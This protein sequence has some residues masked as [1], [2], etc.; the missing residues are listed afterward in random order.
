MLAAGRGPGTETLHGFLDNTIIFKIIDGAIVNALPAESALRFNFRRSIRSGRASDFTVAARTAPLAIILLLQGP[1]SLFA[2]GGAFY[3]S[4]IERTGNLVPME[5]PLISLEKETFDAY[6]ARDDV[7][8]Y[9]TYLL[10]NHGPADSVTF[11]FPVDLATPETLNIPNGYDYV[12]ENSLSEFRVE[13]GGRLVPIEKTITKPVSAAERPAGLDPKIQLV[14]R[15]SLMT[16]KF[17]AGIGKYLTVS[18]KVRCMALDEGFEGDTL[19]KYGIRTFLYTFHPAATWGNGRV[20]S[21]NVA[22]DTKWLRENDLPPVARLA[23]P[24]S[25]DEAGKLRWTFHDQDLAKLHDLTFSYDPSDLYADA[26]IKR[27]LLGPAHVKSLIVSS[28]LPAAGSFNYGKG[29]MR[30]NDLRTA[31]AEGAKGPGIGETIIFEPKDAYVTEIALLNGFV[32]NEALYYANA[33]IKKLRVEVECGE[34]AEESERHQTQEIILPDRPYKDLNPR[35]PFAFVDWVVQHPSGDGFIQ[36]VKLTI[37]DV[38]PGRKYQDTAVTE[39]YI[40]G[41]GR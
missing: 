12:R 25:S 18:Y 14:R 2:N 21:L 26:Q 4:V 35:F 9:V 20:G 15:W 6:I 40:C 33:R 19:W 10:A 24:G 7:G 38:Y 30:D 3:T 31:W 11:G 28:T 39:L 32:S 22:I 16:L 17:E 5:K 41:S 27:N 29:S 1:L 23:P 13:D 8:V 37:L 34:G 36:K